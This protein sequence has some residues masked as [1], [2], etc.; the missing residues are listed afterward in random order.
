MLNS[1][2]A[3]VYLYLD[4]A[5]SYMGIHICTNSSSISF[6]LLYVCNNFIF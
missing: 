1:E 2:A 6:I 4:L 5:G 3:E